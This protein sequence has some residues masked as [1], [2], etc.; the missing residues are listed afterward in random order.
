MP[1]KQEEATPPQKSSA[2]A[3]AKIS[4]PSAFLSPH[5]FVAKDGRTFEKV[6][7]SFPKGTKLNGIDIGGFSCDAFLNDF[8]KKDMLEKGRATVSFKKSEPV[9]IWTGKKDDPAH[10]YQRYEVQATDLT[11]AL[12][13]AQD[14]FKA[15]K[16]EARAAEEAGVSLEAEARD[17]QEGKDALSAPEK[18]APSPSQALEP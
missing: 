15:Q 3:Y 16:A 1:K 7:V 4:M 14:D 6:Y 5:T 9:A 10:P 17:M 13:V 11:H 18:D 12:K 8:M 2:D